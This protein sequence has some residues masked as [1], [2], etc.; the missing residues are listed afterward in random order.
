MVKYTI[1]FTD[2]SKR[3]LNRRFIDW[4]LFDGWVSKVYREDN[5]ASVRIY[6]H[7]IKSITEVKKEW[8]I[9]IDKKEKN[10]S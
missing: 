6:T 8:R 2:G 7:C 4:F 3:T 9:L 10:A 5:R 1:E